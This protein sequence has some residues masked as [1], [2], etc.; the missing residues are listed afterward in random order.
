MRRFLEKLLDA[1]VVSF[2][3]HVEHRLKLKKGKPDTPNLYDELV[4]RAVRKS[5]DYVEPHLNDALLF[6]N[7]KQMWDYACRKIELRGL[8]T[9]FGVHKGNSI[10]HLADRLSAHGVKIYGFDSF[11]GLQEDWK[12]STSP[13]GTF[14]LGGNLPEV[15]SNVVLVKGWFN[16]TVPPFLERESS[17]IAFL[18]LDADTYETTA[19]L[20]QMLSSRIVPGTVILFDEY[21]GY[22]GWENGEFKAFQ[23]FTRQEGRSY[24]YLAFSHMQAL[25]RISK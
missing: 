17:S 13:K 25:V 12:G 8:Y 23:E 5:A 4:S 6:Y 22:V 2:I 3:Y 11:E 1:T 15:R 18:H 10:N 16:E 21:V 14:D 20:L 24:D 9:E 7:R 19:N